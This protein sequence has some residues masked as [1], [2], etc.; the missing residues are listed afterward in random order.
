MGA[1]G[2]KCREA[3]GGK[4]MTKHDQRPFTPDTLAD[5]WG[6]SPQ[7]VRNLIHRRELRAY[8][9]G[10]LLRIKPDAVEEYERNAEQCPTSASDACEADIASTG[11]TIPDA[12]AI[13]LRHAPERK[14]R[15]RQ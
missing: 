7:T 2:T 12:A 8:R 3:K 14:P 4:P 1:H 10:R 9:V 15:A 6:V 11:T 5:L 13:S